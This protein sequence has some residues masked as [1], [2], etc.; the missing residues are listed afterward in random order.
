MNK[1]RVAGLIKEGINPY[2]E[3]L[4]ETGVDEM[5]WDDLSKNKMSW[6]KIEEVKAYRREVFNLVKS[7][8]SSAPE[9]AIRNITME[10][11]YWAILL[12]TEHE[13]IHLETSSV[14][15]SEMPLQYLQRPLFFPPYHPTFGSTSSRSPVVGKDYP[16][17]E[18]L[19]VAEKEVVLGKE[20]SMPS[21]G[22]DNEYGRKALKVPAF[23]CSRFQISNGEFHEFVVDGG[24]ANV[25]YWTDAGW[26]WRSFRNAKHPTFW[27][28]EGPQGLHQ[29]RLR[30]LF[31][32]EPMRWDWPVAVN[33]H[34]AA[35]FCAWKS[36]KTGESIRVLTEP[37]FHAIKGELGEVDPI[38]EPSGKLLQNMGINTNLRYASPC[39]VDA[40]KPNSAGFNGV[41]GNAW[42]WCADYFSALP[43]FSVHPFY[44][45]FSTPCFDGLHNIIKGGSF[46]STGNEASV[47]S[48]FHF[49][50]H[51]HQHASF[52][53]VKQLSHEMVTSD[54][55]AP[56]PYVGSYPFRRSAAGSDK[57]RNEKAKELAQSSMTGLLSRHFGSLQS[58][59]SLPSPAA[60]AKLVVEAMKTA[61][62]GSDAK[63]LEVNCGPG[64]LSLALVPHASRVIGVDH[65]LEHINLAR[66]ITSGTLDH[67][68][69]TGSCGEEVKVKL[70]LPKEASQAMVDF[71]NCDPMC[72][73]AEF[74]HF[75]V[76]ILNDVLDKVASPN[77][78][79]GRL[80][81]PR[82]IIRPGGLLVVAGGYEWSENVTP[83]PLWLTNGKEIA[84]RIEDDFVVVSAQ[85]LPMFW[86]EK[87]REVRG[88]VLDVI[89]L[90]RKL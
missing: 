17:N 28:R 39:P 49:R 54:T 57:D 16:R 14:L 71:R 56:G 8:I 90:Q 26:G 59:L 9:D 79:L 3:S 20:R 52:R 22:W 70:Q 23:E 87:V 63:V 36:R 6:P 78:V 72:L 58:N 27:V 85:D 12:G 19:H 68:V 50:P 62:I 31:S 30:C 69:L 66:Q 51:F 41:L 24:Y 48:R 46:I 4:F 35:A 53:M 80:A 1:L 64:A 38:L 32:E 15:I 37:E 75:D 81:G 43:G 21:Y 77:S 60:L 10:S 67:Y 73:P 45:D 55:D 40:G 86:Q 33:Y 44:E 25:D 82:G 89:I 29:Y 88:K 2:Y 34:E 84:K 18:M 61:S 5:S 42:E 7:V 74:M 65:S 83:R 47:F 13:R 11:P 76:V